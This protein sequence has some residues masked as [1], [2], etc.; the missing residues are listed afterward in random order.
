MENRENWKIFEACLKILSYVHPKRL[1][2]YAHMRNIIE[3]S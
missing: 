1:G 3:D 2:K